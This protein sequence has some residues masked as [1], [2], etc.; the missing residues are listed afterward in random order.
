MSPALAPDHGAFADAA[1]ALRHVF[2]RDLVLEA[3]IGVHQEERGQSQPVRI[4][5]DLAVR[6]GDGPIDDRL[7][8]VV[9]YGD[10]VAGVKAIIAAGHVG[11]VETL[12]EHIAEHCLADLRVA[13]ARVRV[14][15]LEAIAE[16]AGAGVEIERF[17]G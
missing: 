3:R 16:A 6:E 9:C 4:N 5:I 12:A 15:K 7:E 2:V 10:L 8:N 1:R 17:R 14:E 11:L 13:R